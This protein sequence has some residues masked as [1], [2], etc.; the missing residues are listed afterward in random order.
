MRLR[1]DS[2]RWASRRFRLEGMPDSYARE[3]F[4]EPHPEA[5]CITDPAGGDRATNR[6]GGT[7]GKK[8][9]PLWDPGYRTG[10]GKRFARA[11]ESGD[12][13]LAKQCRIRGIRCA[14][15][16]RLLLRTF[17]QLSVFSGLFTTRR[18]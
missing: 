2:Q 16:A 5:S 6:A 11:T 9:D 15:V 3:S 13:K 4:R 14:K 1:S 10:F 7:A 12:R 8:A 18:G 17:H